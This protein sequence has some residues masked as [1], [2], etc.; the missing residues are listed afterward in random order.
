MQRVRMSQVFVLDFC[1]RFLSWTAT[2]QRSRSVKKVVKPK[3]CLTAAGMLL[4][5][6]WELTNGDRPFPRG[7]NGGCGS[8]TT[9]A[10][11]IHGDMAIAAA[12]TVLL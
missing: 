2:H 4:S 11:G 6:H 12:T 8:C 10:F 9:F 5:S 1:P 7:S 3:R